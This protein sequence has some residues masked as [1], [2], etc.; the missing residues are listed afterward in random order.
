MRTLRFDGESDDS[1]R[2][3]AERAGRIARVLID[4]C[5]ANTAVR[6]LIA[7]PLLPY[8]EESVRRHPIVRIEFDQAFAVGCMGECLDATKNKSWGAGP[9]VMPLQPD[10][11]VA[12]DR[13]LYIYK[14]NSLYNRRFEQRRRLKELLGKEHRRLVGKAMGRR[15]GD[16]LGEVTEVEARAVR[17]RLNVSVGD[18]WRAVRGKLFLT[19]PPRLVQLEL[20][21]AEE[22]EAN[23]DGFTSS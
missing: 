13:I 7:D 12:P 18:L 4:A 15:K 5:L 3:R 22:D 11:P 20:E 17:Q 9:W 19:L 14:E 16:F 6:E 23:R 2:T 21:L 1:F 8:T 10:D